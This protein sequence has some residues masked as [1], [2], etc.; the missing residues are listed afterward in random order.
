MKKIIILVRTINKWNK[1][2]EAETLSEAEEIWEQQIRGRGITAWTEFAVPFEA[3][4]MLEDYT[5]KN[6]SKFREDVK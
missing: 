1:F 5:H 4:R 3:S 6:Q 2:G